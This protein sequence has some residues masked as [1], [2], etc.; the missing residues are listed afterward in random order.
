MLLIVTLVWNSSAIDAS[1][2]LNN[3]SSEQPRDGANNTTPESGEATNTNDTTTV[4]GD[5]NANDATSKSDDGAD[6]GTDGDEDESDNGKNDN[7]TNSDNNSNN[8]DRGSKDGNKGKTPI[9]KT[10]GN[11]ASEGTEMTD[12]TPAQPTTKT[13]TYTV[14]NEVTT[15]DKNPEF[16]I[17]GFPFKIEQI[18]AQLPYV[19]AYCFLGDYTGEEKELGLKILNEEEAYHSHSKDNNEPIHW[20]ILLDNSMSL[21]SEDLDAIKESL[22]DIFIGTFFNSR[23]DKVTL[24]LIGNIEKGKEWNPDITEETNKDVILKAFSEVESKATSTYLYTAI[25]HAATNAAEYQKNNEEGRSVLLVI[26]DCNDDSRS[27]GASGEGKDQAKETLEETGI[28]MYVVQMSGDEDVEDTRTV[29][30][31]CDNSGGICVEKVTKDDIDAELGNVCKYICNVKL[32]EYVTTVEDGTY[33]IQIEEDKRKDVDLSD[34]HPDYTAENN[35]IQTTI[36]KVEG[37]TNQLKICFDKKV[38]NAKDVNNYEAAY[39]PEG[40]KEDKCTIKDVEVTPVVKENEPLAEK[41]EVILTFED[42]LYDGDIKIT[43]SED[44]ESAYGEPSDIAIEAVEHHITDQPKPSETT[45]WLKNNAWIIVALIAVILVVVIIIVIVMRKV[46][47]KGGIVYVENEAV[48]ADNVVQKQHVHIEKEQGLFIKLIIS[49]GGK[50]SV[51]ISSELKGSLIVGRSDLSD[52]FID[53][54]MMSRQHFVLTDEEGVIYVQDLE[55]TNGTMLNG[56]R[57]KGKQPVTQNDVISA[58]SLQIRIDW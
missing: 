43:F 6:K 2:K 30:N 48:L 37:K 19:Y 11:E 46:K 53:D 34:Y 51:E 25:H 10:F 56:V 36:E 22:Q 44:L 3:Y 52:V 23:G 5:E 21:N 58:G 15:E 41:T 47:K 31:L 13:S 24:Q 12:S 14:Q 17:S 33:E 28:P 9:S 38:D 26:S 20:Y 40:G 7:G 8:S 42:D 49:G 50:D 32:L 4:T 29:K 57:V 55:T 39:T 54:S 27:D 18:K 16:D 35:T 1:A 45:K